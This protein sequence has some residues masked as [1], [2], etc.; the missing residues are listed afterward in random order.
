MV[1]L[2]LLGIGVT[3]LV[4]GDGERVPIAAGFASEEADDA[5]DLVSMWV[6]PSARGRR[7]GER[8][9]DAVAAWAREQGA[10]RLRLWVTEGNRPARALYERCGF[11]PTGE[12]QPLPHDATVTEIAMDRPLG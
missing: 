3:L 8:L 11:R 12:H 9:I 10:A 6:D 7:V 5:V 4:W 1:W 2:R